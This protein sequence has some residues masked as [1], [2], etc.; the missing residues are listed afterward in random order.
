[1]ITISDDDENE[2]QEDFWQANHFPWK[3]PGFTVE[4]RKVWE[5]MFCN[6]TNFPMGG[7]GGD[8]EVTEEYVREKD[9]EMAR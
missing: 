5:K 4:T 7:N 9:K 8:W 6:F 2:S 3:Q 1:M